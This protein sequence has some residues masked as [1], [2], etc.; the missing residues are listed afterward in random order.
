[1]M[2]RSSAVAT[3]NSIC[4]PA[5]QAKVTSQERVI[6]QQFVDV[7]HPGGAEIRFPVNRRKGWPLTITDFRERG[8]GTAGTAGIWGTLPPQPPAKFRTLTLTAFRMELAVLI[9][10][11]PA[12]EIIKSLRE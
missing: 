1:M 4:K 10:L 11:E 12:N 9:G 6:I 3:A 2:L 7:S 5:W 8:T